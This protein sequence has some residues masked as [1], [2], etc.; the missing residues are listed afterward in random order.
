MPKPIA[1]Y[2]AYEIAPC[3]TEHVSYDGHDRIRH[4]YQAVQNTKGLSFQQK[5]NLI[6]TLYGEDQEGLAEAIVDRSTWD[7]VV[8]VYEAI[9]GCRVPR[10]LRNT[11]MKHLPTG[12]TP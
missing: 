11:R 7:D 4:E 9:T 10:K 8:R 2:A 1:R 5:R 3:I 12:A 6:F